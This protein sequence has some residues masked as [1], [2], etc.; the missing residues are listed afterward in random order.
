M[1]YKS[2]GEMIHTKKEANQMNKNL[3]DCVMICDERKAAEFK[4]QPSQCDK[5][6][7]CI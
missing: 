5:S 4:F 7:R 1:Q 2:H 6:A 3:S